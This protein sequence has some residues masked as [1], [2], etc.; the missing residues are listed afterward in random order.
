ME[1]QNGSVPIVP[2]LTLGPKKHDFDANPPIGVGSPRVRPHTPPTIMPP[3]P[4]ALNTER[5]DPSRLMKIVLSGPS[6]VGKTSLLRAALGEEYN[7]SM[8]STIAVD[9]KVFDVI[10]DR[11]NR[12]KCQVW[13]TAGQE[14]FQAITKRYYRGAHIIMFIFDVS[15][16]ESFAKMT[17]FFS[18][19][20]WRKDRPDQPEYRCA[21]AE[22]TCAYLI[23]NKCDID[24]T[25]RKVSTH[26]AQMLAKAYNLIY[27]ETSA[28]TGENVF[29]IFQEAVTVMEEYETKLTQLSAG[30]E[31]IY[32]MPKETQI[33]TLESL[34]TPRG[35]T[36]STEFPKKK[37]CCA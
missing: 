19:A 22:H 30:K 32:A 14:R 17:D 28:K 1:I 3:K 6:G 9:F 18:N 34:E 8:Q 11:R 13:D 36:L 37:S 4:T 5:S 12:I 35:N 29:A 21:S 2:R 15:C 20:D 26:Q 33:V 23:A 31:S 10:T 7:P 25:Q 27:G 24:E 16:R